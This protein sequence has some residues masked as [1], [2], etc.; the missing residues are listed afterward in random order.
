MNGLPLPLQLN[1]LGLEV[2]RGGAGMARGGDE[3][4]EDSKEALPGK[5]DSGGRG[6][7]RGEIKHQ[8]I[9]GKI[10]YNQ[11]TFASWAAGLQYC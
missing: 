11:K 5:E 3:L 6:G 7:D 8:I 4:L 1:R 2:A 10:N 9:N